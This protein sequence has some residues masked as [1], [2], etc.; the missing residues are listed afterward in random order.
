MYNARKLYLGVFGYIPNGFHLHHIL[1]VS[2]GGEDKIGNL[3][4]LH[5]DDHVLIHKLRGDKIVP[6]G[7]L[8]V[9]GRKMKEETKEKISK[10]HKGRVAHNK[11]HSAPYARE[12]MLKDN[13]MKNPE[14]AKKV[15]NKLKGREGHSLIKETFVWVCQECNETAER[16]AT[17]SNRNK[18]FCNKSCA[19]SFSNKRRYLYDNLKG[20]DTF[21]L[22]L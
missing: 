6:S 4:A 3:V 13:P 8:S 18:R 21:L 19:A 11:G 1:P 9:A 20:G 2:C 7:L 5:P 15:S 17:A 10:R 22:S 16:R 14:I 12:R